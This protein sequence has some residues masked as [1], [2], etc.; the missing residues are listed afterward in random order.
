MK[1]N[2]KRFVLIFSAVVFW[3]CSSEDIGIDTSLKFPKLEK[4]RY[5]IYKVTETQVSAGKSTKIE[6]NTRELIKDTVT[7]NKQ[8]MYFVEVSS[9]KT[10]EFDYKLTSSKLYF[11]SPQGFFEKVGAVTVQRLRYPVIK[12]DEWYYNISLGEVQDNKAKYAAIKQELVYDTKKLDNAFRI[13]IRNDSTGL[14]RK[15]NYEVYHPT[16]GLM[17]SELIDED[18]C[19]ENAACIG[20]GIVVTSKVIYKTLVGTN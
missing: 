3:Q 12:D 11:E 4:G 18:Y 13:Q 8:L 19:Q 20:K 14:F 5:W 2:F 1:N 17:F 7:L 6:Y 16:Y 9:K 10:D 15:K